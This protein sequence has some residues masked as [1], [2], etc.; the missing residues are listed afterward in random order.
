MGHIMENRIYSA[1]T[2][3]EQIMA[4]LREYVEMKC[5]EE[6]G[7]LN[8]IRFN[9]IILDDYNEAERWIKE[10]DRGDYDQ[11]AVKFRKYNDTEAKAASSK[12]YRELQEKIKTASKRY[13]ELAD[14][15]HFKGVKA[16]L[17]GCKKCGS[18]I[19]ATHMQDRNYCPVCRADMRPETTL[20]AIASARIKM[21]KA[22]KE[23]EVEEKK[24]HK[25][26]KDKAE[27]YWL[28]KIEYHQ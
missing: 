20:K 17:L 2:K 22:M 21:E 26:L 28:I 13:R 9:D 16:Q 10:H 18:K 23:F 4:E 24:Y 11:L 25:R 6:G 1:T 14:M 19:A 7:S 3:K 5:F 27:I 8:D 12:R 15:P